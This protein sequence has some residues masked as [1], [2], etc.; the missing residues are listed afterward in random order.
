ML[1][2][3]SLNLHNPSRHAA[4]QDTATLF[5]DP[6][7]GWLSFGIVYKYGTSPWAFW[8]LKYKYSLAGV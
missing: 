3:V 5:D 7:G 4:L 1:V 6:F 2:S 8:P